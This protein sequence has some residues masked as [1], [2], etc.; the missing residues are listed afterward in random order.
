MMTKTTG[1]PAAPDG[2]APDD[3]RGVPLEVPVDEE[4]EPPF[5]GV[6]LGGLVV[7]LVRYVTAYGPVVGTE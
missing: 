5:A 2:A 4:P 6:P 7:V 1:V 3:G